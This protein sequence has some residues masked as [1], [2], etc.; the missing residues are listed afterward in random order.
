MVPKIAGAKNKI[1]YL[2]ASIAIIAAN[3]KEWFI[4][5]CRRPPVLR[6]AI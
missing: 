5:C 6:V 1:K 2:I 4:G 3:S